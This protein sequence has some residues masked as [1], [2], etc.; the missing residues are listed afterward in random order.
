MHVKKIS[1]VNA[2]LQESITFGLAPAVEDLLLPV[3]QIIVE[4]ILEA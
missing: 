4:K 1:R 2:E 3:K